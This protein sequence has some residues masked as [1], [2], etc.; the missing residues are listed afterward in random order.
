M[1]CRDGLFRFTFADFICFGRNEVYE[2][3]AA[4]NK[5]VPRLFR[6]CQV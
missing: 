4:V 6:E 5:Q 3:D 2:L 1:L